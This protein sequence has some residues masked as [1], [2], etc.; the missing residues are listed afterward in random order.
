MLIGFP[1]KARGNDISFEGL[2][3][4]LIFMIGF[5]PGACG[6]DISFVRI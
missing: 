1:P 6:N 4:I 2:V 5:P 3:R